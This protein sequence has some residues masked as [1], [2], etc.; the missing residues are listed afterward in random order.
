MPWMAA[1]GRTSASRSPSPGTEMH[2]L[3]GEKQT[4]MVERL[5]GQ[6]P[7]APSRVRMEN[8]IQF[9]SQPHSP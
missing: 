2:G 8:G 7:Q 5:T 4:G 3:N 6:Q 1:T 9:P